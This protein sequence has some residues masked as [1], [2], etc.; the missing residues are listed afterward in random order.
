MEDQRT[1]ISNKRCVL[2]VIECTPSLNWYETFQDV[3]DKVQVE[4]AIWQDVSLTSYTSHECIVEI[5]A[6]DPQH[7]FAGTTQTQH[8]TVKPDFV[9]VRS[10]T[11]SVGT[12]DSRN[13]LY[14]LHFAQIPCLNS[15]ESLYHCLERPL[16]YAE[17]AKIQRRLGGFDNFPLIT[18]SFYPTHKNMVISPNFPCVVKI[19]PCHSGFGKILVRDRTTWDDV[20]SIVALH[21]DYCTAEPCID[22][23]YEVRVQK[24]GPHYRAFK[25]ISSNWKGNVGNV[26]VNEDIPVEERFKKWID[27]CAAMWGGVDICALDILHSKAD[28]KEYIIEMNDTAIGLVHRHEKED[29]KC[30]RD[31]VL[32]RMMENGQLNDNDK[33]APSLGDT[34]TPGPGDAPGA[35]KEEEKKKEESYVQAGALERQIRENCELRAANREMAARLG[36]KKDCT[37]M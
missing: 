18:Q 4:Q 3:S 28:G 35:G 5:R 10:V 26:S 24:I 31:V 15:F 13:L 7:A 19:G 16:V 29:M 20:R 12:L 23:D 17:L 36:Q 14:G 9:V 22:Y 21:G 2:L 8:R 25:R 30:I 27:A 11:R 34:Q 6:A 1:K 32:A 33:V 37:V